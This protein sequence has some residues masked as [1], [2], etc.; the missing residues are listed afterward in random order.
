MAKM[1]LGLVKVLSEHSA[2]LSR[3]LQKEVLL[4]ES[5]AAAKLDNSQ[6]EIESITHVEILA[7]GDHERSLDLRPVTLKTSS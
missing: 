7:A 3:L 4:K 6:P 2:R 5:S 1:C